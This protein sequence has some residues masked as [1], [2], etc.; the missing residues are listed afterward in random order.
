[1][2]AG[3]SLQTDMRV[4]GRHILHLLALTYIAFLA[5]GSRFNSTRIFDLFSSSPTW[6]ELAS[7]FKIVGQDVLSIF[8]KIHILLPVRQSWSIAAELIFYAF[9]QFIYS[10]RDIIKYIF[11]I[12]NNNKDYASS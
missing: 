4:S 12:L 9:F 10:K 6:W 5:L 2:P 7:I 1:M 3:N 8:P 11:I